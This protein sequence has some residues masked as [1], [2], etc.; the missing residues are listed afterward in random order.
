MIRTFFAIDLPDSFR[1]EIRNVQDRLKRVGADVRWVRPESVHLTLK[2]LGDIE[3]EMVKP[4]AGAAAPVA[5][6][7]PA[8]SLALA[9]TGVFPGPGRPRVCWLGLTGDMD[10]LVLLRD[11]IEHAMAPFGFEIEKRAFKPHLTLGR[12][13]GQKAKNELL[14]ELERISPNQLAFQAEEVVFF[15]SDLKPTGAVY[16]PLRKL[17]LGIDSKEEKS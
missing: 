3:E 15:K 4:L 17:P 14:S 12:F 5:A 2:F 16:T 10:R 8:I 13:R 11:K 9:G 7:S 1:D 6:G